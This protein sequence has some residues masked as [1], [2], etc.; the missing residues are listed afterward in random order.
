MQ[1]VLL[2]AVAGIAAADM[3]LCPKTWCQF[4]GEMF[5]N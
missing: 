3:P 2:L 1:A 5:I 4:H